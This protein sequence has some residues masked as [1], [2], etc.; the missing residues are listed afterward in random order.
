[1]TAAPDPFQP[2]LAQA[3]ADLQAGRHRAAESTYREILARAPDHPV[4]THFLGI[5]M[6]QA[7]RPQEGLAALAQSMRALGHQA[8]FRHNDALMLAQAGDPATAERELE[9]AIALEPGNVTSHNYLGMVRQQLGRLEDAAAAYRAALTISP[10]DPLVATNYGNC[11]LAKGEIDAAIELLRRSV[12][13]EPRNPVAQNNLGSALNAAGDVRG[14]IAAYRKAVETEPR[15]APGWY[16]LGLGLREI[17]DEGGSIEAL[18]RAVQASPD[19]APAWQAFADAFGNSRFLAWDPQAA[20]DLTRV[21]LHPSIDP[22]PL[23]EAAASLLVLDPAFAPVC[24]DPDSPDVKLQALA[25]PMLLALIE[26]ALVPDA[27]F[28]VFLRTLRRRA[29]EDWCSGALTATAQS[30]DLACALAQQCFLNEYVW[31]ES[32]PEATEVS[33]LADAVRAVPGAL[34]LALLAAYRPLAAMP[35]LTRPAGAG[36]SVKRL[37]QRQV[38]EPAEE[39]RLRDGIEAL[40]PIDDETSRAVRQQYEENPYPRWHR[41]PASLALPFPLHRALHEHF[42]RA[43]LS[44]VRIPESPDILIAGCGSGYQAAITALR[45]PGSRILAVDLSRTSL[46]YALRRCRELGIGH[47]RFAQADILKLGALPERFDLIECA[48]VLHHLREPLA[49]WRVLVSLLKPGGVMKVA[50][51]SERARQGVVAARELIAR[52]G[53]GTDLEGVRAARQLVLAEPEGSPA[54]AVAVG[55][56]FYAA[57]GARDL[58][59]H[60]QEHRFTTA[61]LGEMLR[62]LGLELL[63]FEF[64]DPSVPAAYRRRFPD[65]AP[66]TSLENWGRFEDE[67]PEVF[68]RMYQFWAMKP[69]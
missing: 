34:E 14:A 5:C 26:N 62:A 21:L 49:G 69:A 40:T 23:A 19:F 6:V 10:D 8:R 42:P 68:V 37:W 15:Y 67:H 24:R 36:E 18:R 41:V 38:E 61:Q 43:D 54:R 48:G 28:E 65:D 7:G 17:G 3:S 59:M 27:A 9:E 47:V 13:R 16:N 31:P 53:L 2:L 64:S 46:A 51:Y 44:R 20:Q 11:L 60:V 4:A 25:H 50:L 35:G 55:K 22:G 52:H 63:G 39:R 58:V 32:A 56:D 12:G 33:R 66:A 1:M 29:L 57:S 30:I 45:N